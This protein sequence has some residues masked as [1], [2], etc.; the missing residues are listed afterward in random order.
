[1]NLLVS[2]K[3]DC[4]EKVVVLG[5]LQLSHT[6][7]KLSLFFKQQKRTVVFI[8]QDRRSFERIGKDTFF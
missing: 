8:A 6:K 5:G 1:M 4:V 3:G 2:S 7:C